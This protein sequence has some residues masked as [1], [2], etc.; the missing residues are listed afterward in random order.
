[1]ADAAPIK[2]GQVWRQR[3]GNAGRRFVVLEV[4]P[5]E[6]LVERPGGGGSVW[7]TVDTFRRYYGPGPEGGADA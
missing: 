1:M 7:Y 2:V 6:V 3:W 4:K 5:L